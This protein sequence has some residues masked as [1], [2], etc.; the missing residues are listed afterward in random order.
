MAS[1][2]PWSAVVLA[3]GRGSRLG[4]AVKPLIRV[5]DQAIISGL[6][7]SLQA[8]NIDRIVVVISPHTQR[9]RDVLPYESDVSLGKL[10]F[11]EVIANADQMHSLHQ[12]L[13]ALGDVHGGVIVC[14]ADQ[15]F[16]DVQAVSELKI[17]FCN[18]AAH[19]DMVVP[20][21]DGQPGNPVALSPQLVQEWCKLDE[22]H[23]GKTW[24]NAN[25]QRVYRWSTLLSQYTTD[26][27]TP[28]D[29]LTLCRSGCNV[30]T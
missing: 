30:N 21:V 18:R 13:I 26:L 22:A 3:A 15:P 8:A 24:R 1:S 28:E 20:F 5:D 4:G 7:R 9:I 16:V 12:G 23:I 29:L 6:I 19:L 17:A 14:L 10:V 27:D 2:D 11:V 25:P